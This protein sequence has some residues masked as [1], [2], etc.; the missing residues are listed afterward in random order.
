M[1]GQSKGHWK[2]Q[3]GELVV[4]NMLQIVAVKVYDRM[5]RLFLALFLY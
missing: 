2:R 5:F 3:L 4:E 1:T